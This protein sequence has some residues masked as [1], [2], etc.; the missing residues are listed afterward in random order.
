MLVICLLL[1]RLS[2]GLGSSP[3]TH[4]SLRFCRFRR[5]LAPVL[6]SLFPRLYSSPFPRRHTHAASSPREVTHEFNTSP[7]T[8]RRRTT[9]WVCC[10]RA[11]SPLAVSVCRLSDFPP[12]VMTSLIPFLLCGMLD[13]RPFSFFPP[14]ELMAT[15]HFPLL[16]A[17]PEGITH[18]LSW[19][20]LAL[21]PGHCSPP[22]PWDLRK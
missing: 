20:L 8:R 5:T 21:V 10:R 11:A 22:H 4:H 6:L 13:V 14:L 7:S 12:V 19:N 15:R 17:A 16:F 18:P 9:H 1:Q 2:S 3:G